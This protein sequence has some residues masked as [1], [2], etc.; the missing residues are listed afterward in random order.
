MYK[1][2]TLP[3]LAELATVKFAILPVPETVMLATLLG[4]FVRFEPS[5]IK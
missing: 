5:P 1:L 2:L 4:K 3:K